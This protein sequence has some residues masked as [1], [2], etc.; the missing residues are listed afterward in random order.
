MRQ[1][2][3]TG[4]GGAFR[5]TR[6]LALVAGACLLIRFAADGLEGRV[7]VPR[8]SDEL[9][10]A[11]MASQLPA[12]QGA[13]EGGVSE[14]ILSRE[15][16]GE[17]K[18]DRRGALR[19][20]NTRSEDGGRDGEGGGEDGGEDVPRDAEG[21]GTDP[22]GEGGISA[23]GESSLTAPEETEEPLNDAIGTTILGSGSDCGGAAEGIYIKNKTDYTVDVEGLL[24]KPLEF[25]EGA[26]VLILHTHGSEAYN[27]AG[28]D[29]YEPSDPSRT[30]DRRYN[31]VRVGEELEKVLTERGITVYHDDTLHDYPSYT[32]AYNRS[33]E[34]ARSYMAEHPE[35][36]VVI[37]LHRDALEGDG[38]LYKTVADVGDTPCAQ[39]MVL[40]GTNF[41]GLDHPDWQKNMSFAL[42]LQR[43]MVDLYPTLA[44]PLKL[45]QYRYNQQIAPGALIVEVGTNGN[46]LREAITAARYFGECL[47]DVLTGET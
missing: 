8:V 25:G 13:R 4:R 31:V 19:P 26:A 37:D 38:K 1:N 2:R 11:L 22:A 24:E 27:P 7:R 46:T 15:L 5:L 44:R 20:E 3:H 43:R 39:V 32:G 40:C 10:A 35:I 21:A 23:P 41:S 47:A 6:A 29:I 42:K 36:R 17:A 45:S 9:G 30:E 33:L 28:E 18:L 12:G 16:P 34:T 14:L